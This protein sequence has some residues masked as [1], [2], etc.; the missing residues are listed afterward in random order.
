MILLGNQSNPI[1]R[2]GRQVLSL[3]TSSDNGSTWQPALDLVRAPE[4][5]VACYPHAF[6]DDKKSHLYVTCDTY[7]EQYLLKVPFNQFL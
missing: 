4:N 5:K 7:A 3:W 1:G 6:L 2:Q